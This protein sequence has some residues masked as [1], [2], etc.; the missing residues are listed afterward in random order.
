MITPIEDVIA[1]IEN[2]IT[3]IG[4]HEILR[5]RQTGVNQ[6]RRI[7]QGCGVRKGSMAVPIHESD[8]ERRDPLTQRIIAGCF[9]VHST[10]GPGFRELVYQN[11]LKAALKKEKLEF[12][13]EQVFPV[14]FEGKKVGSLRLDLI[15]GG[16][17]VVE[18]KAIAGDMP[19]IF[20]RQVISYL[21]VSGMHVGLLVNFGRASCHVRRIVCQ[22][23]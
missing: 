4:C 22:S 1:P 8:S 9:Q 13:T 2:W 23:A 6:C 3:R 18:V 7:S 5:I 14:L 16:K 11:A 12:S 19:D 15:V 10:L 17:V 21:K 20:H